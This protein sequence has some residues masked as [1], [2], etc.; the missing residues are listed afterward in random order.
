MMYNIDLWAIY[1]HFLEIMYLE[2]GLAIDLCSGTTSIPPLITKWDVVIVIDL[3]FLHNTD[4]TSKCCALLQEVSDSRDV[5][6]E[7][8]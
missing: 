8:V 4:T 5:A 6:R 2:G 1:T 3:L 7:K